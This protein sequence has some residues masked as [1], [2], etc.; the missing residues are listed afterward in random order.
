MIRCTMLLRDC[1]L[2]FTKSRVRHHANTAPSSPR[3]VVS[4]WRLG[5]W[6]P[7]SSRRLVLTVRCF[8]RRYFLASL[9]RRLRELG[10][11]RRCLRF[12]SVISDGKSG[13][14]NAS[15]CPVSE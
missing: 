11:C 10:T 12:D 6:L 2:I 3:T 8:P 14:V 7:A 9:V 13:E 4:L 1:L 5:P 15:P